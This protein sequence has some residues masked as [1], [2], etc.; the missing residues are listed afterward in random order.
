M[1]RNCCLHDKYLQAVYRC[2]EQEDEVPGTWEHH[3]SV[4]LSELCPTRQIDAR[5]H[6]TVPHSGQGFTLQIQKQPGMKTSRTLHL[7][8]D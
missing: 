6:D 2:D 8:V 5:Q 7:V 3:M 4:V 1:F